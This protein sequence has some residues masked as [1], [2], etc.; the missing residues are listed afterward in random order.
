M[1]KFAADAL[2]CNIYLYKNEITELNLDCFLSENSSN[3]IY[4]DKKIL[5]IKFNG[6]INDRVGHYQAIIPDRN[7]FKYTPIQEVIDK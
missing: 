6:Q 2:D 7:T 3:T 5:F 1:I 4:Q